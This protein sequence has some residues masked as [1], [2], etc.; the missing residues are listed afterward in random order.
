MA[1]MGMFHISQ[2]LGNQ[3]TTSP[4]AMATPATEARGTSQADSKKLGP[5]AW[6]P[7]VPD[8]TSGSAG[9]TASTE[10]TV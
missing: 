8:G 3:A 6:E 5:A 4:N 9:T 10:S 2:V 1:W 7:E